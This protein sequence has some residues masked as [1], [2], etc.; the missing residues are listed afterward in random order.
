MSVDGFAYFIYGYDCKSSMY[1]RCI[2]LKAQSIDFLIFDRLSGAAIN[3]QSFSNFIFLL[4]FFFRSK[5]AFHSVDEMFGLKI[6]GKDFSNTTICN[7][8]FLNNYY[9]REGK[10]NSRYS[11]IEFNFKK[12][13]SL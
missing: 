13:R 7:L 6:F 3:L 12:S 10:K 2:N 5:R 9:S 11:K 1:K 8:F 4:F